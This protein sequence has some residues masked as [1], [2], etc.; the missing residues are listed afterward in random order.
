M[1]FEGMGFELTKKTGLFSIFQK[2][3]DDGTGTLLILETF[4]VEGSGPYQYHVTAVEFSSDPNITSNGLLSSLFTTA[5]STCEVQ[6]LGDYSHSKTLKTFRAKIDTYKNYSRHF[7]EDADQVSNLI[8]FI[9]SFE[10]G[11]INTSDISSMIETKAKEHTV[12]CLTE[13]E[14]GSCLVM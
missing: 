8:N 14:S 11:K 12:S 4:D 9:N 5:Q 7:E 13:E 2:C 10:E 6:H 1:K 3:W